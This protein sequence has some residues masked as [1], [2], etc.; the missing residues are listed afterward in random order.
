[1][2]RFLSNLHGVIAVA[3]AMSIACA[4]D[5]RDEGEEPAD[6]LEDCLMCCDENLQRCGDECARDGQVMCLDQCTA[7]RSLCL[8]AYCHTFAD[9]SDELAQCTNACTAIEAACFETCPQVPDCGDSCRASFDT[10]MLDCQSF[11]DGSSAL[12]D[13]TVACAEAKSSCL[14]ICPTD[15]TCDRNCTSE[16]D[17]CRGDCR[18]LAASA[19]KT[20]LDSKGMPS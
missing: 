3:L 19:L 6:E 16:D 10:C 15:D 13:C 11:P 4:A 5:D 12:A 17:F 7:D 9:G 1:M 8:T 18:D 14:R 20:I 2:D